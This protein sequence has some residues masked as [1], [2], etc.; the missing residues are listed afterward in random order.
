MNKDDTDPSFAYTD[1]GPRDSNHE[2]SGRLLVTKHT[3]LRNLVSGT[4]LIADPFRLTET[5]E[6]TIPERLIAAKIRGFVDD[7]DATVLASEP[8][9]IRLQV[10]LPSNYQM[11]PVSE[12]T[13]LGWIT[14]IWTCRVFTSNSTST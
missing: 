8:G 11:R 9:L 5:F 4:A 10:G 3:N 13:L 12:S 14:A 1:A 2:K 7:V 6:V